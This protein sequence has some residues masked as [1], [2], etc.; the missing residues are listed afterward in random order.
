MNPNILPSSQQG[1]AGVLNPISQGAGALSTAWIPMKDFEALQAVIA[2]GVL[3]ASATVDAKLEQATDGAGTG[4][5]DITGKAITQLVKATN[6]NDQAVI[7]LR[8]EELDVEGGFD[9]A[10]LTVT[11]GVAASIVTAI[12]LGAYSH[13]GPASDH[14]LASVVQIVS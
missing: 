7:N 12:V 13:Y 14:D 9:F 10:R 8:A 11:V 4:V 5:K 1:V 3:G 6:D 2:A